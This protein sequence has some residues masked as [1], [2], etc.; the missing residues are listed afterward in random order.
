VQTREGY[1]AINIA[2]APPV[3]PYEAPAVAAAT[4]KTPPTAFPIRG[5]AASFPE[6]TRPGLVPVIVSV[7]AGPVTFMQND[8]KKIFATAFSVV[9]L[10][11]DESGQIVGKTSKEYILVGPLDQMEATRRGGLLYYGDLDLSPGKYTVEVVGYDAPTRKASV[12]TLPLVVPPATDDGPRLSSLTIVDRV[13]Q[14]TAA[15]TDENPYRVG[16]ELLYPNLGT[17]LKKT[18]DGKLAFFVTAYVGHGEKHAPQASLEVA[19]NGRSLAK[20]PLDLPAPDAEGRI[21][22]TNAVPLSVFPPGTYELR[23]TV[24]DGTHSATRAVPFT[25]AA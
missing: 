7:P 14:V 6:S 18:A 16:N 10:A 11:R 9:V 17:P 4:A 21:Q 13:E 8:A 23:V 24:T 5:L 15:G 19:Q 1:Y 12:Q 22:Y 25:V 2:D 3:L 20:L